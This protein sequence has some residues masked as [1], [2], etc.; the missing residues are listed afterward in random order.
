MPNYDSSATYD[1]GLRYDEAASIPIN[2]M[3][4]P[5]LQ[6]KKKSDAELLPFAQNIVTN[7]TGN[8]NFTAPIPTLAALTAKITDFQTQVQ[9]VIEIQSNLRLA[10]VDRDATRAGLEVMLT[11]LASYVEAAAAGNESKILSS[12]M[13]VRGALTPAGPL[14]APQNLV[15]SPSALEGQI[16][17]VWQAVPA[18]SSYEVDC[19]QQGGAATWER[20]KTVTASR[21]T[22]VDLTPGVLYGFRVRAIGSAGASPWCDLAERRAP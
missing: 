16:D 8:A 10:L 22:V 11:Q 15:A 17:L 13:E 14:P 6:L 5:K 1:S 21:L 19:R 20:V 18:S 12:G 3:A 4:K 7:M 2:K 9:T